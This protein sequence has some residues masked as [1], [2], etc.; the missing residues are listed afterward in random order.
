MSQAMST[1]DWIG[2]LGPIAFYIV[3]LITYYVY[4]G[5]REERLKDKY[6][7]EVSTDG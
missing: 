2:V 3:S 4:E 5:R 1:I 6:S 7:T